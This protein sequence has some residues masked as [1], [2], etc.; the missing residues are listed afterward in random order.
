MYGKPTLLLRFGKTATCWVS[1]VAIAA[2][3]V[4]L[5]VALE[6]G[7]GVGGMLELYLVA[8]YVMLYRLWAAEGHDAEQTAIGTLAKMGN[9]LLITVL[10]L[11]ILEGQGAPPRDQ[12][13]F[14]GSTAAAYGLSFAVLVSHP[15]RAVIGYRG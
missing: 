3:N 1:F 9:G 2:G 10:G 6:P 12:L 11:L 8:V 5:L 7:V 14:A 13:V 15:E 4:L